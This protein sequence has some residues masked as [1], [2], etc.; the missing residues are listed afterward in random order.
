MRKPKPIGPLSGLTP[1][2]KQTLRQL[3]ADLTYEQIQARI[4]LPPPDG[5]S[6]QVSVWQLR[7]YYYRLGLDQPP[8]APA[9]EP[10]ARQTI[11][12]IID[13]AA[14]GQT[15]FTPAAIHL[16]EKRAFELA[17]AGAEPAEISTLLGIV[18]KSRDTTTRER[19]AEVQKQKLVLKTRF[20]TQQRR[21]N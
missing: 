7:R 5:F 10:Q 15:H 6:I 1:E 8:E 13:Q 9:S 20:S 21:P 4:A 18:L 2:Q 3:Y 14:L 17:L 16:L 19:M 11:S 12:E